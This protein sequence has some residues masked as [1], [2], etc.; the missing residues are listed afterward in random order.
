MSV[1][2]LNGIY[3]FTSCNFIRLQSALHFSCVNCHVS[4]DHEQEA[5]DSMAL[6]SRV[7]VLGVYRQILRVMSGR[8]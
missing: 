6:S 3:Q 5:S 8:G 2:S 7:E 1:Q 4:A